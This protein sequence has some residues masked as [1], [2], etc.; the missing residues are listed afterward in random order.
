MRKIRLHNH[1]D[2]AVRLNIEA[3]PDVYYIGPRSYVDLSSPFIE[4]GELLEFALDRNEHEMTLLFWDVESDEVDV[5]D[6]T[7]SRLEPLKN[8]P[9]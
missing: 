5:F 2:Q 3:W 7:G 9:H 6:E 4:A 1:T 8:P